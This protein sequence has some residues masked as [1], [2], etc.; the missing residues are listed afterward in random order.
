M[1]QEKNTKEKKILLMKLD[2]KIL[3]IKE[4]QGIKL[5]NLDLKD[6]VVLADP[7]KIKIR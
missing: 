4:K 5:V 3:F 2:D 1:K 6:R 7:I